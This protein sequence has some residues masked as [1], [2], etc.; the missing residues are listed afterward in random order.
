MSDEQ[1]SRR[2]ATSTKQ[3]IFFDEANTKIIANFDV[4]A[5]SYLGKPAILLRFKYT[6]D[7][8]A[9]ED[10]DLKAISFLMPLGGAVPLAT[11]ILDAAQ[12]K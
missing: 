10:K 4:D 9:M 6:E 11:F 8:R 5:V 1:T 7:P 2:M 12:E 3:K